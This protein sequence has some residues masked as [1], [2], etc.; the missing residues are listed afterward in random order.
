MTGHNCFDTRTRFQVQIVFKKAGL[1]IY[2]FALVQPAIAAGD[3]TTSGS[4]PSGVFLRGYVL[5]SQSG[6]TL[7]LK[8]LYPKWDFS[9]S[10]SALEYFQRKGLTTSINS[11]RRNADSERLKDEATLARMKSG[12]DAARAQGASQLAQLNSALQAQTPNMQAESARLE[13][14]RQAESSIAN[15]AAQSALQELKSEQARMEA[16][17]SADKARFLANWDLERA[18]FNRN[19]NSAQRQD[20]W[21]RAQTESKTVKAEL[22]A[23]SARLAND[24]DQADAQLETARKEADKAQQKAQQSP[25]ALQPDKAKNQPVTNPGV[26]DN[27]SAPVAQESPAPPAAAQ[28][29]WL[30][31]ST[32]RPSAESDSVLSWDEWYERISN[33]IR[34]PLVKS[35]ARHGNPSG[36]DTVLITVWNNHMLYAQLI[37]SGNP[38]FDSAVLEAYASLNDNTSLEFPAGSCRNV[39]N[40]FTDHRHSTGGEPIGV[41]SQVI[42]GD[43]EF[44]RVQ[45]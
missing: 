24:K 32:A 14:Q 28:P 17:W 39:V 40:F 29:I 34:G 36:S 15:A 31:P 5:Q 8:Y 42:R 12:L 18:Q 33:L 38:Q 22:E 11:D 44:H 16:G 25:V 35:L 9:R 37:K 26:E 20:D 21:T 23:A 6:Q 4:L 1:L 19:W 27:S 7:D 41:T 10:G 2:C 30:N 43:R 45:W 3:G 13:N